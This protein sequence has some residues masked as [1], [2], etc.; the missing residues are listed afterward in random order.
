MSLGLRAGRQTAAP[1][2]S[3]VI[4]E[5]RILFPEIF[6]FLLC[7]RLGMRIDRPRRE[8]PVSSRGT[9]TVASGRLF[10]DTLRRSE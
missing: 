3:I 8:E 2:I 10:S 6:Y 7:Y 5:L 1:E 4:V 9:G